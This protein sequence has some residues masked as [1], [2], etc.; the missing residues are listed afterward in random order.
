LLGWTDVGAPRYNVVK[1]TSTSTLMS[2]ATTTATTYTD[3]TY[4]R[5]V[6]MSYFIDA[7]IGTCTVASNEVRFP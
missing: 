4:Y 3:M 6:L 2:V 5:G 7:T 1:Y